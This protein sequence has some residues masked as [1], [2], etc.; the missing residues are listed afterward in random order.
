MEIIIFFSRKDRQI[1]KSGYRIE[2]EEIDSN[3][4]KLGCNF[5]FSFF[6]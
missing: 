1:K 6:Y 3:L 2:L 5:A 4:R